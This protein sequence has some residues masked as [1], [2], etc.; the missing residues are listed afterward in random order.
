[1]TAIRCD[2]CD[3]PVT[4]LVVRED[5]FT[6]ERRE[7]LDVDLRALKQERERDAES[8]ERSDATERRGAR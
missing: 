3:E 5:G 1:M 4:M 8:I 6:C 7:C 2:A